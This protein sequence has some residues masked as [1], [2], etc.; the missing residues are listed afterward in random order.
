MPKRPGAGGVILLA[1]VL[2]LASAF[3]LYAYLKDMRKEEKANWDRVV[4]ALVDIPAKTKI[5]REMIELRPTP[6]EHIAPE[7]ALSIEE[8]EG[9]IARERI[10]AKEQVRT[11]D[12]LDEGMALSLA[13]EIPPGMRAVA[14]GGGEVA[15]VGASV[16]PRDRIDILATFPDPITNR[17]LTQ[18]ILQNITVLAVNEGQTDPTKAQGAKTSLTV[19]VKPEHAEILTAADRLGILRV[20]LRPKDDDSEIPRAM[21][22]LGALAEHVQTQPLRIENDKTSAPATAITLLPPSRPGVITFRGVAEERIS[23]S[24]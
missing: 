5:T 6:Q 13:L 14:I 22:S 3:F 11:T 2:G 4:V 20:A 10:R 18:M 19:V 17:Q 7:V 16:R 8:V 23:V 1:V 12:V 9:K 15:F 24:P 21:P